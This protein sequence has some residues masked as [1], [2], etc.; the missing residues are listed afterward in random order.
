VPPEVIVIARGKKTYNRITLKPEGDNTF[1]GKFSDIKET[2]DFRATARTSPARRTASRWCRRRDWRN[3]RAVSPGVLYRLPPMAETLKGEKQF[4]KARPMTLAEPSPAFPF[5]WARRR[6]DRQGGQGLLDVSV[7][8]RPAR[9][10]SRPPMVRCRRSSARGRPQLPRAFDNV[11][12]P[13]DVTFDFV[14]T[15]NVRA[16]G[17]V[18]NP[19]PGVPDVNVMVEVIRKTPQGYMITPMARVP[20]SGKVLDDRGLDAVNFGTPCRS[21]RGRRRRRT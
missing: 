13:Q 17:V 4:F 12:L 2:F 10:R 1:G 7:R 6:T 19:Q 5:R 11:R 8:A 15:D 18:I 16:G 20:F 21:C 9:R 14:D 3:C